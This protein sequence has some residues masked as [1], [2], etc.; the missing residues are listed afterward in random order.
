MPRGSRERSIKLQSSQNSFIRW[1]LDSAL[2][3]RMVERGDGIVT[4]DG[5][6][7]MIKVCCVIEGWGMEVMEGRLSGCYL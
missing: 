3:G 1:V 6:Y 4:M 2:I 7:V 5:G